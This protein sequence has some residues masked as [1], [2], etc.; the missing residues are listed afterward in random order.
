MEVSGQLHVPVPITQE[1]VGLSDSLHTVENRKVSAVT[2]LLYYPRY[3]ASQNYAVCRI[4]LLSSCLVKDNFYPQP[5]K[6]YRGSK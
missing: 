4:H 1:V 3:I 5:T 6:A 2:L